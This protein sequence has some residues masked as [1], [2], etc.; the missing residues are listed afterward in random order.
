MNVLTWMLIG[1][2]VG[3]LASVA[4]R[5]DAQEQ[6]FLNV[7]IGIVGAVFSGWFL[8]SFLG[9]AAMNQ[10]NLSMGGVLMSLLGAM[11]LLIIVNGVR[12]VAEG[13][14]W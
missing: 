14:K 3:W 1:G 12:Y 2:F 4:M 9:L 8:T 11:A 6:M 13:I 5:I 10:G 7:A